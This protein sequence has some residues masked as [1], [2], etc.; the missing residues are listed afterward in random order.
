MRKF[1]LSSLMLM[2]ASMILFLGGCRKDEVNVVSE[3]DRIYIE[4]FSKTFFSN[5][6]QMT[7][8][9]QC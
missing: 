8:L 9:L 4:F 1:I 2:V 6:I 3:K 7:I 5:K